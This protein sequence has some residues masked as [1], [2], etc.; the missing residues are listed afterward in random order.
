MIKRLIGF[1]LS[2][3]HVR[4]QNEA[5]LGVFVLRRLVYIGKKPLYILR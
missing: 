4:V 3:E 1:I 5:R 2:I